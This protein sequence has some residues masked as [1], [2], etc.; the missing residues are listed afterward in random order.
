LRIV[1]EQ[2]AKNYEFQYTMES[3]ERTFD[4]KVMEMASDIKLLKKAAIN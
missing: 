4:K 1:T 3:M 2:T